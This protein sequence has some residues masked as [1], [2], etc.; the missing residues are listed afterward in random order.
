MQQ[1]QQ[2]PQHWQQDALG[3]YPKQLQCAND[4]T[5]RIDKPNPTAFMLPRARRL[6]A[7]IRGLERVTQT[8]AQLKMD[9][10]C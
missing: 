7:A 4:C 8:C 9:A 5:T 2:Q 10:Y 3:L 6:E 1:Q